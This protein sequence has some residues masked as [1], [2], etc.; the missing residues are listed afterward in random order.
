MSAPLMILVMLVY[1]YVAIDY[2]LK[3][4]AGLAIVFASYAVSLIGFLM[5][6]K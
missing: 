1:F 3:G 6:M 4:H 5:D 2:A